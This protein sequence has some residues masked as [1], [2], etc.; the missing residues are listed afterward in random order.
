[1]RTD[2]S[3]RHRERCSGHHPRPAEPNAKVPYQVQY[4]LSIERGFG[5]KATGR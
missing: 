5:K 1:M 3:L 4:G 2:H